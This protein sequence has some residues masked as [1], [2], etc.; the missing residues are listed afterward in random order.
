MRSALLVR[1]FVWI[2][3]LGLNRDNS[4]IVISVF[5]E[6]S[7]ATIVSIV[8]RTVNKLLFR[9]ENLSSIFDPESALD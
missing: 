6:S 8:F 1:G 9:E 4:R 5:N 2:L 3:C 7:R